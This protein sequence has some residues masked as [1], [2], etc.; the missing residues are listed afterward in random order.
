M[1]ALT[2]KGLE[3][4]FGGDPV[5]RGLDIEIADGELLVL[6]GPSG[7][8]KTTALRM[9]AGL[10]RPDAGDVLVGGRPI[11]ALPPE[12]RNVGMVFQSHAL[13][14]HKRIH[15]NIAYGLLA[16]GHA[17]EE[18]ARRVADVADR[19]RI[20]PLLD[21]L[22]RE[23]SGGERQRAALARALVRRPD[24]L[25]LDEPLSSL[26]AQLRMELRAEI[27][28]L[29]AASSTTTVYVTHDQGEALALGH[30]VAVLNAGA[31]EQV[32][33]PQA[34]YDRPASLFVA[35]FLGTPPMNLL[36]RRGAVVGVRPEHVHV[37]GSRWAHGEPR[38]PLDTVV[39]LV[40]P[41][42]DHTVL[43]LRAGD[44]PLVARVEPG[45]APAPGSALRAWFAPGAEHRFDPGTGRPLR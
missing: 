45:F 10:E 29:Q 17:R 41:A 1:P 40:E 34:V 32:G 27:A 20:A 43:R 33:A 3:K 11:T 31:L 25:L 19:L 4:S 42:G 24:V 21:R 38:E 35:G 30:R 39:E 28:R 22:P 7:S 14:P 36:R 18:V 16:R 9:I 12:R 6:V 37:D 23:L 2:L 44:H 13:F 8:G 15:D 5:V 26:D